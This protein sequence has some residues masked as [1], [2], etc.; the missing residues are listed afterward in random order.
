MAFLFETYGYE[1]Q[2]LLTSEEEVWRRLRGILSD[3]VL[4]FNPYSVDDILLACVERA[5]WQP[6]P[7]LTQMTVF[8][9]GN[10]S[11]IKWKHPYEVISL[12]V[13]NDQHEQQIP[14]SWLT[15]YLTYVATR[16]QIHV[17]IGGRPVTNRKMVEKMQEKDYFVSH[18]LMARR[19]NSQTIPAYRMLRLKGRKAQRAETIRIRMTES[20]IAMLE[21]V[22]A[23]PYSPDYLQC[24]RLFIDYTTPIQD[25][26]EA[27]HRFHSVPPQ[28]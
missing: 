21:E 6:F 26:I 17:T 27:I 8:H 28:K 11:T 15:E 3:K 22:M 20:K 2:D 18:A 12:R 5:R 25:A 23:Y 1:P 19:I 16:R 10:I 4:R 24:S 13:G 7:A 9:F 14:L